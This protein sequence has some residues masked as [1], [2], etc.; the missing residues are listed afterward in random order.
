[1]PCVAWEFVE[2][3]VSHAH[4]VRLESPGFHS[5]TDL[6][7]DI[8]VGEP[9]NHSVLGSVVLVLVL[10]NQSFAGIVVSLAL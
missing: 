4:Y 8:P 9:D 10:H 3:R 6:A 7:A 1:M 2:M 5:V